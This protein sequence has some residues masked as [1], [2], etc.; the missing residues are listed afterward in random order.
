[1]CVCGR[2]IAGRSGGGI[3]EDGVKIITITI[4]IFF[5][6]AKRDCDGRWEMCGW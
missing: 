6:K 4:A 3:G 1:M 5:L 2:C